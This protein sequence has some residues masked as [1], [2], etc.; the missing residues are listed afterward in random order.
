MDEKKMLKTLIVEVP[1]GL[2]CKDEEI[3]TAEAL[4]KELP[5]PTRVEI[6]RLNLEGDG[7]CTGFVQHHLANGN[8]MMIA[9]DYQLRR[10]D[11]DINKIS[12]RYE[13]IPGVKLY[14]GHIFIPADGNLTWGDLR[15]ILQKRKTIIYHR[16][17]HSDG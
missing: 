4:E 2:H 10:A 3:I 6:P 7:A 9:F 5:C 11:D 14:I 15:K 13:R 1:L 17:I 16:I 12:P 8:G